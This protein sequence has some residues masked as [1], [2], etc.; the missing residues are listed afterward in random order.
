MPETT[1]RCGTCKNW[2]RAEGDDGDCILHAFPVPAE[3]GT[4]C[5]DYSAVM[6]DAEIEDGDYHQYIWGAENAD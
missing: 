5:T 1:A 3:A 6:P 2:E 4:K